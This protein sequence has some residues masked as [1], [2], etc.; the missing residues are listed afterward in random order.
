MNKKTN[1]PTI[2]YNKLVF[3]NQEKENSSDEL[4]IANKELA[5]QN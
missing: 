2:A 4:V 1:L 3:Q 5:Y